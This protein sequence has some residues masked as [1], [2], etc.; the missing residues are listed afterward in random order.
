MAC[1]GEPLATGS[2]DGEPPPAIPTFAVCCWLPSNLGS[3]VAGVPNGG[4]DGFRGAGWL[5]LVAAPSL[6]CAIGGFSASGGPFPPS[7]NEA[8][9]FRGS[10]SAAQRV[11]A[12]CRSCVLHRHRSTVART[13]EN[14][15]EVQRRHPLRKHYGP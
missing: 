9:R 7:L 1:C 6:H 15:S 14:G 2:E 5:S 10:P 4:E 3:P 8:I 13:R 12:V 11:Q